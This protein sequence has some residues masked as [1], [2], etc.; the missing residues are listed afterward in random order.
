M[1]GKMKMDRKMMTREKWKT[2]TRVFTYIRPYLGYFIFGMVM[3]TL[4]S[5]VMMIFLFMA[6]EMANAAVEESRFGW[7][8]RQFGWVFII[9]L[10]EQGLFSY[11]RTVGIVSVRENGTA[12]H[13]Q[14]LF[15]QII[16]LPT[17]YLVCIIK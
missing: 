14:I 8:V 9:L 2:F 6:G 5:L 13:R 11:L 17:T 3:L 4:S 12:V 16:H 10:I 7:S 1:I 15:T